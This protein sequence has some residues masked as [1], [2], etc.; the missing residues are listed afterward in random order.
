[1][2][3][4]GLSLLWGALTALFSLPALAQNHMTATI[5]PTA[6]SGEW[7]M[8]LNIENPEV[9]NLTAFQLDLELPNGFTVVENSAQASSRLPDH[10]VVVS[11]HPSSVYKVVAYS[12]NNAE[13]VGNSGCVATLTIKADETIKSGTYTAALNNILI[14][15]RKGNE[16][17]LDNT[18]VTWNYQAVAQTY[19][20]TYLVDGEE[21]AVVTQTAGEAPVLPEEPQKE[22][23]TFSGWAN[24]PEVMPS[25]NLTVEAVFMVN[26]YTVTYILDGEVFAEQPVDYGA[27]VIPPTAPEKEGYEFS[28]WENAPETMPAQD[29]EIHGTYEVKYYTLTFIVDGEVFKTES[30]AF[31]TTLT[32]P[33][34]P[35]KEGYEF[36]GWENAP[37][38]M[39]AQ[40][41]EIHGTYEVKYYTLT[42]IVDGEVFKTESVAFGT[43]ITLPTAPEKE[44]HT[45]VGW[46]DVPETMPA[47][48]VTLTAQ[49][50]VNEYTL[51][52]VLDGA[53]YATFQ[54]P[55][56]TAIVPLEVEVDATREFNGWTNLPEVMPA[57]DV[58]V[59]GTTTL[60]NIAGV[61]PETTQVDIYDIH[62]KRI[63]TQVTLQWMKQHLQSGVYVVNG[64]KLFLSATL[65]NK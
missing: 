36:S 31:G 30:V 5:S 56:G 61:L 35:E 54:V 53:V 52:Y 2:K 50:S 65:R 7:T 44:G 49:F 34:A 38:T 63:A 12:L 33:T 37:E 59:T 18:S 16:G 6:N 42:F 8:E 60:T 64:K 11:K 62:G 24:L 23:H 21:Y 32:L 46:G 25:E 27:A 4:K 19:T 39:P 26:V 13:I 40:D 45:F 22:G 29:L 48:D 1:M 17:S 20:I 15:D 58:T 43:T 41:L 55:Y 57:H 28:G 14:S 51:T 9:D 3:F 47:K 10:T